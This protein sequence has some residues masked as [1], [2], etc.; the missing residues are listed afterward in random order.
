[1]K[2]IFLAMERELLVIRQS[3]KNSLTVKER[4]TGMQ[5]ICVAV[6]PYSPERIYCG[7]FARGLWRSLDGGDHWV[8]IGDPHLSMASVLEGGILHPHITSLAISREKGAGDYGT[9][10]AGTE[11]SALFCSRD[12]GETWRELKSLQH[13]PS[14][15]TWSFPPRPHTSHVR[16]ITPDPL[17]PARLHV[18]IEFGAVIRSLDQGE[19]WSDRKFR[20]PKDAHTLIVHPQ[21]PD[22]IYAACGDG[23][24]EKGCGYAES[25]DGGETWHY[26]GEGLKHHY[27]YGLAV[28]PGDPETILVSAASDPGSAHNPKQATSRIYR[29]KGKEPW[30]EITQ[31]LP[32]ATGTV[33][34]LLATHQGE[35]GV[36]YALTNQGL[37][38]S[39]DQGSSWV[40]MEVP[41]KEEY[42]NQHQ[43]AIAVT[44]N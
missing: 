32:P 19:S 27:L 7:T 29:K 6:D 43:Q 25:R 20:S 16:W 11:P 10:Y 26:V 4:L 22:R 39:P 1:M 17:E 5:P 18:S 30:Q 3:D 37:Y 15:P 9:L 21:N 23:Y 8:P 36:F 24:L 28:D 2:R 41:W 12:G 13:L 34:P 38:C 42:I 40:R 33:I 35:A 44:E 31:G 14:A